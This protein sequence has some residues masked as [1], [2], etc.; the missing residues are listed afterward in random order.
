MATATPLATPTRAHYLERISLIDRAVI[1]GPNYLQGSERQ[2]RLHA[3]FVL[4][5]YSSDP[6]ADLAIATQAADRALAID[7]N[8]LHSLRAKATVL[9]AKGDWTAAEALLRR[10]LTLQPTE[11]DRHSELGQCLMAQ[12]RHH[13]ALASF[14]TAKQFAGGADPVYWYDADIA[15]ASLAIG[16]MPKAIAAAQLAI[17]EMPPDTARTGELPWLALI[18]ATSHSGDDEAARADLRRFLAA[19]RS[20]HSLAEVQKWPAFAAN[21]RLL[22]GL[23][24]AGMLAE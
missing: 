24:R 5:G 12:G 7:P 3:E 13:D 19:P 14:Q 9:R 18:A 4:L 10:V 16:Q 1:L 11:A 8:S 15:M 22:D 6:I 21:P 17:G 23:R 2:A 20:W